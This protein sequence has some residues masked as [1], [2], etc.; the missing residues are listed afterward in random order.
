MLY[1]GHNLPAVNRGT[2]EPA[3]IDPALPIN[4]AAANC[5]VR[6]LNYWSNYSYADPSARAS[7]L[8][9]LANGRDDPEADIGYVFLFLRTG[10][11]GTSRFND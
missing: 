5:R 6:M 2:V 11:T 9:W 1:L 8:Q 3:L 4:S 10:T 7:Y